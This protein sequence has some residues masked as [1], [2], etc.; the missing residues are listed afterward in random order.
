MRFQAQ[1]LRR[2][3]LPSW[4]SIPSELRDEL[5]DAAQ[6]LD[7]K[8]CNAAAFKMYGMSTEEIKCIGG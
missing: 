8:A 7:L 2:I 5:I 3:R 4:D 6:R 1:Y